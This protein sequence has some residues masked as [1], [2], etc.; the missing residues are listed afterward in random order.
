M[1]VAMDDPS[2]VARV[3][4]LRSR[5]L[6]P[7]QIAKTLGMTRSAIDPV[8]RTIAQSRAAAEPAVVGCW[9]TRGWSQ[10][11]CLST[12]PAGWIDEGRADDDDGHPG[13]IVVAVV[14][15]LRY[16][17]VS[18]C[19]YLVDS[20]CLGVKNA[21]G[22]LLMDSNQ[23]RTYVTR[24][25]EPIEGGSIEAPIELA[26]HLVWGALAYARD[27]GFEP[28]RDF[29]STVEHLGVSTGTNPIRFGRD[30]VPLYV[31]GPYD[32]SGEIMRKLKGKIASGDAHFLVQAPG[33]FADE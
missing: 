5:G 10:G 27:L 23:L 20:M 31:A 9:I 24:F 19:S 18:A 7:K 22:P 28:H 33:A 16:G 30:G 4:E 32:N 26:R 14:R 29:A 11:L 12:A 13:L 17:K 1:V 8:V 15:E 3:G 2:L 6:T 25:F 21:M